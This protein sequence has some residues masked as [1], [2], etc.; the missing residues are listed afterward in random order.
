MNR[1][2]ALLAGLS[3][4]AAFARA[5]IPLG[6]LANRRNPLAALLAAWAALVAFAGVAGS[7]AALV[8]TRVGMLLGF[9]GAGFIA[10]TYGWRVGLIVAAVPA[11]LLFWR[12]VPAIET[13]L[14]RALHA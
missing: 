8:A 4:A 14:Q 11:V 6:R 13:D 3:Y 2:W 7:F 1:R 5:G 12:A 9:M 10:A